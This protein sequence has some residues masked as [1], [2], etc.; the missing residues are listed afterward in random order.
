MTSKGAEKMQNDTRNEPHSVKNHELNKR[1]RLEHFHIGV[2]I[3]KAVSPTTSCGIS[4][5]SQMAWH[6]SVE[7]VVFEPTGPFHRAFERALGVAGVPYA[8]VNPRQARRFAEAIGSLAKTDRLDAAILG[9]MG[10]LLELQAR[11]A[12]SE[13][14][15]ELKGST[16]LAK[17]W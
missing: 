12:P 9:A 14:L 15:L 1:P 8:K 10:A 17:P 7:R 3:S 11:P 4:G 6:G 5:R 16:S 13:I 2:D